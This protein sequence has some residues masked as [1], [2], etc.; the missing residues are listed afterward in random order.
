M[1]MAMPVGISSV[2][3]GSSTVS[4]CSMAHRS[5]PAEPGVAYSG[6]GKSWPRRGSRIL[7]WSACM[8]GLFV[9]VG[10]EGHQRAGDMSLARLADTGFKLLAVDHAEGVVFVVEADDGVGEVMWDAQSSDERRVGNE[11]VSTC[12]SRW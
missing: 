12:R 1:W 11:C 2:W 9:A 7:A 8:S 4:L 5:R 6:R 3:P 10:N